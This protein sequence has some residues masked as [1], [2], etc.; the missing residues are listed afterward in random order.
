M[1]TRV[2]S[3]AYTSRHPTFQLQKHVQLKPPAA[4]IDPHKV[5]EVLYAAR[6]EVANHQLASK[7]TGLR[8]NWIESI[9]IVKCAVRTLGNNN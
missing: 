6:R 9:L 5:A 2:A 8:L 1:L 7:L 3:Y 4:G